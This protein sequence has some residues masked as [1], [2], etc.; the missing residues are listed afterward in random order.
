M[1]NPIDFYSA[2]PDMD[3]WVLV[4]VGEG[5]LAGVA[6]NAKRA[7]QENGD[8]RLNLGLAGPLLDTQLSVVADVV[9][10]TPQ[11]SRA[12]ITAEVYQKFA[13]GILPDKQLD[14][15]SFTKVGGFGA[16]QLAHLTLSI[17]IL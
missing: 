15:R 17:R 4:K 13:D 10:A 6:I 12:S 3:L 16:D 2:L 9:R 8:F 1:P 11:S 7:V 5:Q 14:P